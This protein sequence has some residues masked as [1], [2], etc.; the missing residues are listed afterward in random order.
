MR[1]P[2]VIL[3]LTCL[4]SVQPARGMPAE[5]PSAEVITGSVSSPG[6]MDQLLRGEVNVENARTDESGGTVRVQILMYS[7]L[8]KLWDY[9]ASCER[10]FLYVDGL[11]TCELL[12]VEYTADTDV[13]TLRQSV[14]KSWVVPTISYTFKVRRQAYTQIDFTL[15]EGDLKIMEGGWR[16]EEMDE[17]EG[18]IVTHEIRVRPSFP[19]PRWLLRRSMRK[20]VPDM[21]VCL[22]GL[23]GGSGSFSESDDLSHCPKQRKRK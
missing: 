23:T 14:K 18:L 16:F 22:R 11:K 10:V 12:K 8:Q 19:V 15:V 21:L 20:D 6:V 13:T 1:S 4:V 17:G 3:L 9:I 7:D 2:V 5:F